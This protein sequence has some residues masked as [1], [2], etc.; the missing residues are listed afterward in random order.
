MIEYKIVRSKRK[1]VAVQVNSDSEVIVRAPRF[2]PAGRI[3]SFV[4]SKTDWI[5]KAQEKQR[6]RKDRFAE[7]TEDEI[8]AL[9]LTAKRVLNEKVNYYSQV[10]GVKPNGVK[11]TS[12]Q[13][14]YGS[15][16]S[17]G[18]ICFSY[19]L[20]LFPEEVIDYVVVHELA[21]LK[22]LNHSKDFYNIVMSVLPDYKKREQQ[23][24]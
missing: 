11:I 18:N 13:K 19:R 4:K 2:Y 17:K 5:L 10:M 16:N 9:K 21:H 8:D 22:E 12:A 3:D 20:M 6:C 7:L 23:L 14:R 24:K 15:C 1:T